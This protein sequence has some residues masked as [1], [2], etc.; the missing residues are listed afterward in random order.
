MKLNTF[1]DFFDKYVSKYENVWELPYDEV[2]ADIANLPGSLNNHQ[3]ILDVATTCPIENLLLTTYVALNCDSSSFY[4]RFVESTADLTVHSKYLAEYNYG[5]IKEF[6]EDF[7]TDTVDFGENIYN[8]LYFV[9]T[10]FS[11]YPAATYEEQKYL[12][13]IGMSIYPDKSFKNS[14]CYDLCLFNSHINY[15]DFEKTYPEYIDSL[16]SLVEFLQK[17]YVIQH[18][19]CNQ[20][21][22]SVDKGNTVMSN[23]SKIALK[24]TQVAQE[25]FALHKDCATQGALLT[26]GETV[27]SATK[28][29]LKPH[30]PFIPQV[31]LEHPMA[32]LVV[33]STMSLV[34]TAIKPGDQ[35]A[36]IAS[37]AVLTVGYTKA[38]G[39][40]NLPEFVAN[41]LSKV[42]DT[43]VKQV[44]E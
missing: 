17:Y 43:L 41:L 21:S 26:I 39:V 3:T 40:L 7:F 10:I 14:I 29:A 34:L 19:V 18:V 28:Q 27:L 44:T 25:Q 20:S 4:H 9:I 1:Q 13:L 23:E 6:L 22:P 5:Y 15:L 42:P 2:V 32:D 11:K 33:A 37:K 35:K 24:T 31:L 16:K 12:T 8:Y 30:L 38:M 36:Q